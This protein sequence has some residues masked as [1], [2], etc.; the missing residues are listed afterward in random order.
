MAQFD[1][2]SIIHEGDHYAVYVDGDFYCSADT[3]HEAVK[4]IENCEIPV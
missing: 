4:E 2:V 3:Y 1:E